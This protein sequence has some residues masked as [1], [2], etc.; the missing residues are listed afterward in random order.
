MKKSLI[1]TTCMFLY[2]FL[3]NG[4]IV[5]Q[6]SADSILGHAIQR[7]AEGNLLAWYRP[8]T[9]GAGYVKVVQLASEFIKNAPI[10]EPLQL[11]M[12]FITCCFHENEH[13]KFI[14]EDWMHN[15]ACVWAGLVQ[16]LVLNYRVYSGDNKYIEIVR[17]MLDYHLKHG[18]T[19]AD[20]HWS[21][22]PFASADPFVT[23][24]KGASRWEHEG[25]RGDGLHGIEPDKIG[26]LG[27][28]YLRF[29]Q[30]TLEKRFLTAAIH[31]AEAL[32][33]HV[34]DVRPGPAPFS[35]ADTKKSPWPF[36]VNA[37]TN[38]VISEYCSNVIEPIR[39][40]DELL[41]I[42]NIIGLATEQIEAFQKARNLAWE[43]L[44][45]INGPM[46]TFIW[47]AYFEDIPNDPDRT[48]RVQITPLETARYLIK[49]PHFDPNIDQNVAVLIQWVAAV[50]TTD[51]M[52]AIKEQTWCYESM[53]SH[54][55]RYASLCALWYERTGDRWYKEQAE[56]FFNLATYMCHEN[57]YVSVGPNWFGAWWSDGYGDYIRHFMEGIA[58]VP[59]WAPQDENHLLKSTSVIQSITYGKSE[60]HYQTYDSSSTET[61]RLAKK[62]KSVWVNQELIQQNKLLNHNSWIW[63]NLDHG[64]VLHI[65]HFSGNN[66]KIKI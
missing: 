55:A 19:P 50:F 28:A 8:N 5:P 26:E 4:Q 32:A 20:W 12:Y 54:T 1:L 58:A 2:P 15:P 60:I 53:G 3:L 25:M 47:N 16:G 52:D 57:G 45:S 30:V 51:G 36:R 7:D 62:P 35:P 22:V 56:R 41:R 34:R 46:K 61:F 11:P 24:Y 9:P 48:N 13:G 63:E 27:I 38:V 14:A 39:L 64:G 6:S 42:Q 37:R 65:K 49:N 23:E 44:Y 31:C 40:F 29:Y 18:T 33:K 10:Y 21:N 66:I 43:W 59:E 17:N